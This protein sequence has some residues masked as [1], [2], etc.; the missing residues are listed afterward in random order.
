M[1]RGK[2]LVTR[3]ESDEKRL[4]RGL[5]SSAARPR[6][7]GRA[8]ELVLFLDRLIFFVA[9]HWLLLV[10]TAVAIYVGLPLSA[11]L[12]MAR[13]YTAPAR[14]IYFFYS[15]VCHQTPSRSF[16]IAGYQMAFCQRDTATY[17]TILV[18]GLLY[19][20]VRGRL[21][22]LRLGGFVL[23]VVPMAI[24]GGAQLIGLHESN[25]W[26]RT[27]TGSLFGLACVW[28]AYPYLEK[29]F[30]EIREDAAKQ[31]KKAE[32]GEESSA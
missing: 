16:F 31:L 10:N 11:P 1:G 19:S 12:L 8:R 15:F 21:S 4:T 26:L 2:A 14:V 7:T 28:L 3:S 18:A 9:K 6:F 30:L 23:L 5:D 29:G 32:S 27:I 13:G 25:W 22:P 20:L 24:D 17:G